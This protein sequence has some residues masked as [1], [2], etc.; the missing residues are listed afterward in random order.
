VRVDGPNCTFAAS[1]HP[2]GLNGDFVALSVTDTGIGIAPANVSKVFEPF[3]TTKEVGK[4]TGL[5]LSQVY[6]FAQQTAGTATIESRM[7]AG[8]SV[9]LYLPRASSEARAPLASVHSSPAHANGTALLVEDDDDVA[10][11]VQN[12]LK[13]IGYRANHV[14]EG[15]TALAL[16]LSGRRFD[17][18][19]SDII[20]PGGVNDL[21]LARKVR[22]HF[23]HQPILLASGHAQATGE[24]Y[25][26][27][28]DIIAKPYSADALAQA[29]YCTIA[30]S[31]V[32]GRE[33][34]SRG[35]A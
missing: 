26:E 19:L 6:G 29:L 30:R 2:A 1:D 22:Q 20:M 13:M 28:F 34:P 35:T 32:I 17:V 25:S 3:F 33:G 15:V 10:D 8:T 12:L 31:D 16:L 23:P 18:V 9:T 24:V 27:G 11:V 7:G 21:D 14:R 4:G 5:G